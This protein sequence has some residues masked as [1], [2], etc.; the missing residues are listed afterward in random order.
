MRSSNNTVAVHFPQD[1]EDTLSRYSTALYQVAFRRLRNHEDA[2]DAVQDALLSAVKHIS[3]F[4]GRSQ[5]STWLYRIVI[6]SARMQLRRSHP[7]FLSL[8]EGS[9]SSDSDLEHHLVDSRLNPEQL[10]EKSEL[11]EIVAQLL[12]HLSPKLRI[13]FQLR[14]LNSLSTVESARILGVTANTLKSRAQRARIKLHLL[15]GEVHSSE[16]GTGTLPES[17]ATLAA[18]QGTEFAARLQSP[19]RSL[20]RR[21]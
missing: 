21:M 2:E 1:F 5:I 7:V 15:L 6:N 10:C 13:A 20:L 9:K 8:D 11:H 14:H 19:Y 4:E 3:Q 17:N 18:E 12:E 16:H